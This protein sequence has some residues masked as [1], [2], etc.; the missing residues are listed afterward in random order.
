MEVDDSETPSELTN[1]SDTF[2]TAIEAAFARFL[3]I[4]IG[5]IGPQVVQPLMSQ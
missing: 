5:T 1:R 4:Y 2:G 3:G